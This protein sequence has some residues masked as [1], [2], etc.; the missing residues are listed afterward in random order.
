MRIHLCKGNSVFLI[1]VI[2]VQVFT[3][4]ASRPN[5][6]LDCCHWQQNIHLCSVSFMFIFI[7][8]T[9]FLFTTNY[10]GWFINISGS[11]LNSSQHRTESIATIQGLLQFVV[12]FFNTQSPYRQETIS[13]TVRWKYCSPLCRIQR[14]EMKFKWF[15][16]NQ[17]LP[18]SQ[19]GSTAQF[20]QIVATWKRDKFDHLCLKSHI[21]KLF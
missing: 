7:L 20:S 3:G 6:N 1:D 13:H 18:S 21:F 5:L 2:F 14:W 11:Y 15:S 12:V 16:Q 9:G 8:N 10:K 4:L 17:T 19:K